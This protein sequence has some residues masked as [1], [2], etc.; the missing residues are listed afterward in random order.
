MENNE[1][2]EALIKECERIEED[3]LHSMKGHF[4]AGS[5]WN[6]VHLWMGIPSAV[7]AAWAGIEAFNDNPSLTATLAL[8]SA[9]LTAT[10]TF[11]SP[12]EV[13]NNHTKAGKEYNVVRNKTRRVRGI[14]A[15]TV[16]PEDLKI[17]VDELADKKD[18]LNSMSPSIPRWAY[19]KAKKDIDKGLADYQV[20]KEVKSDSK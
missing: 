18:S 11:L 15:L 8:L 10:I 14:D 16:S 12:Q 1:L 7:L 2:T 3:C 17:R 9:A 6:K 19:E 13:S 5:R 4:N 20:D